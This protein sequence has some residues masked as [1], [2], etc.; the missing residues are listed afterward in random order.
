MKKLLCLLL[1]LLLL[2]GFP[3]AAGADGAFGS[4]T[5]GAQAFAVAMAYHEGSFPGDTS[6]RDTVAVWAATGWYAAWLWR[7]AGTELLTQA[8]VEDFQRSLGVTGACVP[9]ADWPPESLGL[10]LRR[11]SDGSELYDFSAYKT[12]MDALL[13]RT[14]SVSVETPEPLTAAV[15]VRQY[16]SQ[17]ASGERRYILRFIEAAGESGAFPWR[18]ESVT[19]EDPGPQMDPALDFDW[20]GLLAANSLQNIF[21][22]HPAVRIGNNSDETMATWLFTRGGSLCI[23]R[24]WEGYTDGEYRGCWFTKEGEDRPRILGFDPDCGDLAA[25][26]SYVSDFLRG[27]AAVTL[28]SASEDRIDIHIAFP[29]DYEEDALIDRGPLLLRELRDN[30]GAGVPFVNSFTYT[31]APDFPFL[32]GWDRPLRRVKL[33]WEDTPGVTRTETREIPDDWEYVPWEGLYG[34]YTIYMDSGYTRPWAYPGDGADYT[35]Y[36]TTAKG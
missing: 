29:G 19:I 36:L 21:S 15:T 18:L 8:A 30:E 2:P 20:D 11:S 5:I 26:D 23:V 28:N 25:R 14:V 34:D 35:L 9:P 16:Y 31:D 27:A 10:V 7:T 13:G 4:E 24:G 32:Y 33:V 17:N 6:P 3:A 12:R 1:A 22:L